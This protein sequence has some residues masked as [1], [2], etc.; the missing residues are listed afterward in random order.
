[1]QKI[2]VKI[3]N[4][5]IRLDVFIV[6]NLNLKRNIV[7][8]LIKSKLISVNNKKIT[9]SGFW[10]KNNYEITIDDKINI[11]KTINQSHKKI[12]IVYEDDYLIVVD[13]PKNMLVHP[14]T[15]NEQD[16]LVNILLN[17][18]KISEFSDKNRPGIVHR[19]D[20]NTTGL[21]VIA[22]DLCTYRNLTNQIKDKILVRKYLALVHNRF[23]DNHLMLK[24]PIMRSKN[25]ESK[26]TISDD[27]K[28]K[29]AISEIKVLKNY[30]DG[31]LIECI[32]HTGRTHQIRVHLSY[33]HHPVFNDSLYGAYD[34]Y[35]DYKQFLHANYLSFIHP[36]T[37]KILEFNSNPD[38]TFV[39]LE[40]KLEKGLHV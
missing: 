4:D 11:D 26:M 7:D 6:N 32:L 8:K 27:S 36:Y 2:I 18:I 16:T 19:L 35:K 24:L 31:S 12:S 28:A 40:K 13:K 9:K 25:N 1:M 17:K 22:K 38:L 39:S 30:K 34:G 23:K 20:R 29:L 21:I 15:F 10:L 14:T 5:K 33:I 37:G 3:P